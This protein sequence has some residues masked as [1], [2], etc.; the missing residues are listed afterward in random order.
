MYGRSVLVK[1][2]RKEYQPEEQTRRKARKENTMNLKNYGFEQS[3]YN[4]DNKGIPARII[5]CH[6]GRFE[7]VSEFGIGWAIAKPSSYRDSSEDFPITGDYVMIEHNTNGESRILET[8]PRLTCFSRRDPSSSGF[9]KQQIA[10]NFDYVFIM[11]S[12]DRDFSERRLERYL[13][14]AWHSGAIPAIILT[15][16]DAVA[17]CSSYIRTVERLAPYTG[18]IAISAHT[19]YGLN[20][21]NEYLKPQ[22]SVVLLGS[23]GVGKSS[24]LNT[25]A[26]KTLMQTGALREKDGRGKHTTSHRQLFKLPNGTL[27]IDT[28]GM[29]ELGIW[30]GSDAF[31]KSFFDIEQY[32][33]TCKFND[34]RHQSEPGCAIKAAIRNGE[35]SPTRWE[36][37]QKLKQETRFSEDKEGFM[38][39]KRQWLKELSKTIR[40][41]KETDYR[42]EAC[43]ESFQCAECGRWVS[44]DAA[45]SKHR[46][47]CP[48]CLSSVHVDNHP[49]DRTSLCHGIMEPIGVWVRKDG[50]WALIH[51]CTSCGTLKSNRI[52]A[53]DNASL[54]V[55]IASQAM[56]TPPF[57]LES[58]TEATTGRGA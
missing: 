35:L 38:Q 23:S 1:A 11:Q 41:L 51:R 2:F 9:R 22:K 14:L 19:G 28:P 21:L 36:S 50:E 16:A 39:E 44:P 43:A 8:L 24:L 37:Y 52:A 10:A 12:L 58:I 26:G 3:N 48:H 55:S 47:H 15:K 56:K 45:G 25:L 5:A 57:P 27:V 6:R 53:D 20:E 40:Q 13:T 33:G 46:N 17:D 18:V 42:H 7:I 54:L 34:C 29:R 49:G 31:D 30:E 4:I 32:F